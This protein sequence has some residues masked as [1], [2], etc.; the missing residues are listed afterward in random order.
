[1][2]VSSNSAPFTVEQVPTITYRSRRLQGPFGGITGVVAPVTIGGSGFRRNP[3][4]QHGQLLGELR[5][6]LRSS[7]LER[8]RRSHSMCPIDAG[9]GPLT[10]TG[11][12]PLLPRPRHGSIR[13]SQVTVN[14]RTHFG[15][16]TDLQLCQNQGGQWVHLRRRRG[17]AAV[18][19]SVR[20]NTT[21]VGGSVTAMSSPRH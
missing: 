7:K 17:R 15:N 20:G 19:C 16:Q 21:N 1:V 2:T 4:R 14:S 9:T 6:R 12:R 10:V 3:E 5:L 13:Q 11:R 8:Q 18:T